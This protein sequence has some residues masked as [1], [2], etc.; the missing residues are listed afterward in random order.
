MCGHKVGNNATVFCNANL[1]KKTQHYTFIVPK[2]F[3]LHGSSDNVLRLET[4]HS[5]GKEQ[6]QT[7]KWSKITIYYFVPGLLLKFLQK[8]TFCS[9]VKVSFH[10]FHLFLGGGGKRKS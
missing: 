5:V 9:L 6:F 10:L 7:E 8:F 2:R 3:G 1:W 4:K